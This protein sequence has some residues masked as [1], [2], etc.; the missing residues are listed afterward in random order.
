MRTT[1]AYFAGVGTVAVAIAGGLGGGLLLG[2]IMSPQQPKYPS[3]EVTRLE[4]RT[5]QQPIQAA[6]GTTQPVPYMAA[7]QVANTVAGQPAPPQQPQQAP[8]QQQAQPQVQ[9]TSTQP[10]EPSKQP[11]R[12]TPAQ[13]VNAAAQPSPP[14]ER[15]ATRAAPEDSF[16]NARETDVKNEARRAEDRRKAERRQQW[17]DKRKWRQRQDDELGDVASSVREAT[18]ARSFGRSELRP[19]RSE[20]RLLFGRAP[21]FGTGRM[22]LFDD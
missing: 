10:A 22:T 1:T 17:A 7:T 12:T 14:A 16:A 8:S 11:E 3:S 15:P 6:N 18:E 5:S 20:P 19:E 13:P 9:Q 21:A 4:Q 2:D